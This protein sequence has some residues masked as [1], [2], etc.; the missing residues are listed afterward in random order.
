MLNAWF[1]S[2]RVAERSF[3][4]YQ[5]ALDHIFYEPDRMQI[6]R[7]IPLPSEEELQGWIP[8]KRFP[9]DHLSVSFDIKPLSL[10]PL[11]ALEQAAIFDVPS[12]VGCLQKLRSP[13]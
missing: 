3:C 2:L 5:G 1:T 10:L 12:M 4:R 6:Q 7:E 8:S 9:S 11:P 13:C